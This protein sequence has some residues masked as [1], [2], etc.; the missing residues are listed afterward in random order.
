M[1][2]E[3]VINQYWLQCLRPFTADLRVN[4]RWPVPADLSAKGLSEHLF[5]FPKMFAQGRFYCT[6]YSSVGQ[7][8]G[9][10]VQPRQ[11]HLF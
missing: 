10:H 8:I 6:G 1:F 3:N 4:G 7:V 5:P 11:G 2:E 9:C